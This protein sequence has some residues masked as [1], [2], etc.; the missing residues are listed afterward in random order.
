ML[1]WPREGNSVDIHRQDGHW[2]LSSSDPNWH[3]KPATGPHVCEDCPTCGMH[4]GKHAKCCGCY[5]GVC[6]QASTHSTDSEP[7]HG[8][9]QPETFLERAADTQ[10]SEPESP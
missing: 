6:C 4:E 9:E 8:W 2:C 1:V 7:E 3:I 10:P 5:D